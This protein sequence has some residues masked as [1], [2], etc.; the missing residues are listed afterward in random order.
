MMAPSG[1]SVERSSKLPRTMPGES[2][3]RTVSWLGASLAFGSRSGAKAGEAY[4]KAAWSDDEGMSDSAFERCCEDVRAAQKA[5]EM[6][7]REERKSRGRSDERNRRARWSRRPGGGW[8]VAQQAGTCSESSR[9][10][11]A[12]S[13]EAGVFLPTFS[14]PGGICTRTRTRT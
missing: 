5:D 10:L 13:K 7:G 6:V 8:A 12:S 14:H 11:A 1:A 4:A 9:K 2:R 3:G